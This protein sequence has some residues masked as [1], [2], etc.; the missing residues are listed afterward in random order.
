[1][2]TPATPSLRHNQPDTQAITTALAH[3]TVNGTTPDW[4]RYYADTNAR[5]ISLPTY[6][7]QRRRYWLDNRPPEPADS[8]D[9]GLDS[10]QHPLLTAAMAFQSSDRVVLTGKVSPRSQPWLADHAVHGSVLFPGTGFVELALH[11]GQRTGYPHLAEFTIE[12]PLVLGGEHA[13]RLRV[14][15]EEPEG[16]RRAVSVYARPDGTDEPWIRHGTGVLTAQT[17]A[18]EPMAWPPDAEPIDVRDFYERMA[19]SG[20]AYGPAFRGLREAWVRGDEVFA[21]VDLDAGGGFQLHPAVFDAALHAARIGGNAAVLPFSWAGVSL[22]G[23]ASGRLRVRIVRGDPEGVSS[24]VSL[25]VSDESGAPVASVASLTGRPVPGE[26]LRRRA[27]SPFRL[28]WQPVALPAAAEMPADVVVLDVV[29]EAP[30]DG[31]LAEAAR[32]TAERVLASLQR[33]LEGQVRVVVTTEGAT[34][35]D[36]PLRRLTGAA[37][38]G[39]T[40]SAQIEHPGRIVLVDGSGDLAA[41]VLSGEPQIAFRDGQAAVPRLVRGTATAGMSWGHGTV[42]V[43]GA[44]GALGRLVAR[45]LVESCGVRDLLLV[46]RRGEAAPGAAELVALL[47]ERGAVVQFAACDVSDRKAL[48]DVLAPVQLSAVVHCAGAVDDATLADQSGRHLETVFGPKADAAWHLHEL[49]QRHELAAFVLFSSAAGVLGSAGQANYA[50]ANA[51]LDALAEL[52]RTLGQPAVSLAWGL[53]DVAEGMAGELRDADR[54]RLARIGVLPIDAAQGLAM[55]DQAVRSDA[56]VAVPLLLNKAA[57]RSAEGVP[58]VLRGFAPVA[59]PSAGLATGPSVASYSLRERIAGLSGEKRRAVLLDAVRNEVAATLG[60]DSAAAL[61]PGRSFTD[62]GF[63][64]LTAVELRNR[65]TALTDLVLP[66]AVAF[67][68]PSP[69]ALAAHLDGELPPEPDSVRAEFDRLEATLTAQADTADH[70]YVTERLTKLLAHWSKRDA[71][72]GGHA[73]VADAATPQELMAFIDQ[74]L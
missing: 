58:A 12:A 6:P 44:S 26:F 60:H 72:N 33:A 3:L 24:Q 29:P 2:P 35:S 18:G 73:D 65:L 48:A 42:L 15:L 23:P 27:E 63:D 16:E 43:T 31:D 49:T 13:T 38:W 66:A 40:R 4:N 25:Q 20:I 69:E 52:R 34:T 21:V 9:A 47:R 28:D 68:H 11:A 37:V 19:E 14:E 51:F 55:L 70:A 10:A 46:S 7:F 45:H 54:L 22:H 59:G 57:L 67:D 8:A 62:L 1:L 32:G 61:D 64:S 30:A 56:A 36:D 53:W 74:N 41:A 5:T 17:L 71:P 39:L 50:A